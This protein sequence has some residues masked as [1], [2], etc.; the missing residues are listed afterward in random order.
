M[1][2]SDLLE[3]SDEELA[4]SLRKSKQWQDWARCGSNWK[5]VRN[6]IRTYL[7]IRF[8]VPFGS[9]TPQHVEKAVHRV[10][11]IVR[12]QSSERG[13]PKRRRKMLR[14]RQFAFHF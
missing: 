2:S 7:R 1:G 11:R 9:P 3:W 8:G 5:Y 12:S 6:T 13:A 4:A 14:K 10:E